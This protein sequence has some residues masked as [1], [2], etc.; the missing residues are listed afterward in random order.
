MSFEKCHYCD[1]TGVSRRFGPRG[2]QTPCCDG[3][4]WWCD[5]CGCEIEDTAGLEPVE[6]MDHICFDCREEG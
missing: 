2:E 5:K 6:G 4:V 3:G 1:G